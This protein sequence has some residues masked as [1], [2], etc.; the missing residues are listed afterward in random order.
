VRLW[1]SLRVRLTVA[2]VLMAAC[3]IAVAATAMVMLLEQVTLGTLDTVLLEE[4]STLATLVDMPREQLRAAVREIGLETDTGPGK[5]VRVVDGTGTLLAAHHR[6]PRLV[7][8]QRPRP[9]AAAAVV[10]AGE[11]DVTFRVAWAPT[12]TGGT[13]AV[14]AYASR[15]V[16][17]VRRARW[18]IASSGVALLLVLGYGAWSIAGRATQELD[19][20]AD[21]VSTIEAGSLERRL[22]VRRTDEVDR[23]VRV[24]NRLLERLERSVAQ[25]RRFTADA[26]HELRTPLSALRARLEAAVYRGTPAVSHEVVVDALEQI[27]RLA[28]LAE[29]L[30]MLARVEGG[31]LRPMS[32]ETTVDMGALVEEVATAMSAI[33]D[34]QGRPFRWRAGPGLLV[35]G[36]EPLLKRTLLNLVDNAFRHTPPEAPVVLTARRDGGSAVVEIVDNG[37]GIDPLLL[38]HAFERFRHGAGGGGSGL[39]LALVQEIVDRHHGRVVLERRPEGGT[40]AHIALPLDDV[41]EAGDRSDVFPRSGPATAR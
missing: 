3:T 17:F 1:R 40:R 37:P 29:D 16:R 13:V 12:K 2:F 33:A 27:G 6:M 36:S 34:E 35:R 38:P 30:L 28:H 11:D 22:S 7:A 5:F 18:V 8:R 15:D 19:R 39:G 4:A 21:E 31:T 32:A 24:L 41:A 26:A 14:G 9:L 10:T 25:L 23:L 20:L